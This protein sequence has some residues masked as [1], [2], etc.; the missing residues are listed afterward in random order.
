M[1]PFLKG[2][3]SQMAILMLVCQIGFSQKKAALLGHKFAPIWSPSGKEISFSY[4]YEHQEAKFMI[5]LVKPDNGNIKS[6]FGKQGTLSDFSKNGDK[7]L[8]S[9]GENGYDNVYQIKRNGEGLTKLTEA[10]APFSNRDA[11]WSHDEAKIAFGRIDRS[12]GKRDIWLMNADGS[13]QINLTNSPENQEA[14]FPVTWSPDNQ[15][16]YYSYTK[17]GLSQLFRKHINNLKEE[18][19]PQDAFHNFRPAP[20]PDGSSIAFISNRKG[21]RSQ[22]D[23]RIF[24]MSLDGTNVRQVGDISPLHS[25][26]SWSPDGKYLTFN[27]FAGEFVEIFT[28][29]SDGTELKQL[30]FSP[31]QPLIKVLK[32]ER[33]AQAQKL[34][35][36]SRK[37][38]KEHELFVASAMNALGY[39]FLTE[40]QFDKA[41]A[42]FTFNVEA[43]P[44]DAN[45]WDSL[46]E[47]YKTIGN[48]EKAIECFKK[49]LS[50]NP[51]DAV[52][53]NATRLLKELGANI[54]G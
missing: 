35:E 16:V 18:Q 1:K 24:V 53:S 47:G 12:N 49:A 50:L 44:D 11:V 51:S 30:T 20:S 38:G 27:A 23:N 2:Y 54:E 39:Q 17:N 15:W 34:F 52:K 9:G 37:K 43:H 45:G 32:E 22:A 13:D 28:I 26:L 36:R 5:Y 31:P 8:F 6:L 48:K 42:A 10:V 19:L 29:K 40:K 25:T 14:V 33:I 4:D 7:V 41:L 3:W 46:G 21:T